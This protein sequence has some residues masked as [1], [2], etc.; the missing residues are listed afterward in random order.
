MAKKLINDTISVVMQNTH[1]SVGQ[2]VKNAI[3][4]VV[5]SHNTQAARNYARYAKWYLN[6][7]PIPPHGLYKRKI[8]LRQARKNHLDVFVE[9]GTAG[10]GNIVEMQK[11]FKKLYTI[12]LDHALY[13]QGKA[14]VGTNSK[15]EFLEGDSGVVIQD[16]LKTL[17]TPALF[18]LD[19]HYSGE[20]TARGILD[21]PIVQE[22]K[23]IF[24][25]P[26]KK[27]VLVID[28]M[29]CFD[30]TNDYPVRAEL[31]KFIADTATGYKISY[32]S[33]LMIIE[34]A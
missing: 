3:K 32:E 33:D 30:G 9:T 4:K 31:E 2:S 21:T 8:L 28:D 14:R 25:H 7:M 34:P 18:W 20:G 23:H 22:L 19:A 10:G 17:Q 26:I 27:H 15:I 13:L 5:G 12:E 29:R 24:A 1:P 16:V 11:Y 6:G